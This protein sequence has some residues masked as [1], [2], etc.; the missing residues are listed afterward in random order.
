MQ[1]VSY[2][3]GIPVVNKSPEK[4]GILYNFIKGVNAHGDVGINHFGMDVVDCDVA[5]MQG[6]VHE[7]S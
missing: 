4:S 2:H 5:V 3:A 1:V 6:F 7:F